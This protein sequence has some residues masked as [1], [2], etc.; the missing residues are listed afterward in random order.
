MKRSP[1]LCTLVVLPIFWSCQKNDRTESAEQQQTAE[2]GNTQTLPDQDFEV[3]ADALLNDYRTWYGYHYRTIHLAQDFVGVDTDLTQLTKLAFLTKLAT[4]DYIALKTKLREGIPT[5]ALYQSG[6]A[7][8]DRR[9]TI[10]NLVSYE[11]KNLSWEGKEVPE[12]SF[13]DLNGKTYDKA[14]TKGKILVLKCW[15]ISCTACVEEFPEL[16]HLVEKYTADPDIQFVSLASDTKPKLEAFIKKKPFRYAVV[17]DQGSFMANKLEIGMYPTH[18]LVN[19]EGKI[20][21]VVNY[22]DDL[23]PALERQAK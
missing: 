5:Y 10:K 12:F 14:S 22:V 3:D 13:T 7:N 19:K 8:Q 16:N 4:G 23:I 1:V 20:V 18:L 2:A 17:P 11:L 6:Q 21:K 15:F 9:R